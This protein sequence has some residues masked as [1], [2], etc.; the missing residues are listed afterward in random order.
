MRYRT[1]HDALGTRKIP[2]T[3]LYGIETLRAQENFP[4]SGV[5]FPQE[6][7][8]AIAEIKLAAVQA[9]NDLGLLDNAQTKAIIRA[10]K[11]ILRGMHQ[12]HFLVDAYQA[13][14]GTSTHMNVNEVITNR[15]L[16]LLGKPK[17]SYHIINPHDDVNKGQS[18]NG[19]FVS[20]TTIALHRALTPLLAALKLVRRTLLQQSKTFRTYVKQGRTHL[21][22]AVPITLGQEFH[23]HATAIALNTHY[24]H[25]VQ[26]ELLHLNLGYNAIGTGINTHPSFSKKI[27]SHLHKQTWT[28]WHAVDDHIFATQYVTRLTRVNEGLTVLATDLTKLAND[29]RLLS[30]GPQAGF[31]D[32]TL[33]PVQQGSSIMPGKINP[34]IVE[35]VNMVCFQ[36]LGNAETVRLGAQA[37]QLELNVMTPIIAKNLLES[38]TILTNALVTFEKKCLRGIT[39]DKDTLKTT[40]E[41]SAGLGTLLN[42][43]IGYEKA[44]HVVK[45]SLRTGK[46]LREIILKKGYLTRPEVDK[47]F[48]PRNMTQPNLTRK[49]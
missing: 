36:V 1:E 9:N 22:D 46:P 10:T 15:A 34:S 27:L 39:A 32:I 19:V 42:P 38:I 31:Q 37:G 4:I 25:D 24:I 43:L 33:P 13:G 23:A 49:R 20:A 21:Q 5:R 41:N 12:E 40:I 6:I 8:H 16:E 48:H 11:E 14:A 35:M 45:E 7:Y 47:L 44:T 26:Q 17:G 28:H 29:L 30:S 2:S 3:A 18:T